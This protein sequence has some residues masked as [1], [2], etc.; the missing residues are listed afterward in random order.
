MQI[1]TGWIEPADVVDDVVLVR[2]RERVTGVVTDIGG[3]IIN[4]HSGTSLAL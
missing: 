2:D 3:F 4:G 1:G